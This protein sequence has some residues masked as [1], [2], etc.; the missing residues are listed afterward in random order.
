M[1]YSSSAVTLTMISFP[2]LQRRETSFVV[3]KEG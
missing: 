2:Q 1:L 3:I